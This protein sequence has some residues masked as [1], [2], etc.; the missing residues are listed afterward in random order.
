MV[1]LIDEKF[2][3]HLMVEDYYNNDNVNLNCRNLNFNLFGF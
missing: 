2:R 1:Q 3:K